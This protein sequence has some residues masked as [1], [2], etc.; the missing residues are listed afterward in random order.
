MALYKYFTKANVL[1]NPDGPLSA[2]VPSSVI[3]ARTRGV[4]SLYTVG[5]NGLGSYPDRGRDKSGL[6]PGRGRGPGLRC[7]R[8]G[9]REK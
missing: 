4:A 3:A 5:G 1:P 2:G 9:F 7:F 6:Y 8:L